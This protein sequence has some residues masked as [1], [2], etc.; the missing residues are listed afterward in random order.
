[1]NALDMNEKVNFLA[2]M[3]KH[4]QRAT[5][6]KTGPYGLPYGFL[7]SI[8][9]KSFGVALGEE[10]ATTKNNKF[11]ISTLKDCECLEEKIA[12]RKS[13]SSI[14]QTL[15]DLEITQKET[16]LLKKENAGL[17]ECLVNSEDQVDSL[18][19]KIIKLQLTT[20]FEN[21]QQL[22]TLL[23]KPNPSS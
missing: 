1:M 5:D 4:M 10:K 14:A 3:I 16:A 6:P 12:Q 11:T 23:P 9:F 20:H 8:V 22:L 13:P 19:T 18:K 21:I 2:L 7:L 17:K 15:L